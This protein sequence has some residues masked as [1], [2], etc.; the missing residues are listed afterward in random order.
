MGDVRRRGPR[1]VPLADR[2]GVDDA[3]RVA[4]SE[5]EVRLDGAR[6]FDEQANCVGGVEDTNGVVSIPIVSYGFGEGE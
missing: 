1:R 2:R 5:R 4:A 3:R 6:S